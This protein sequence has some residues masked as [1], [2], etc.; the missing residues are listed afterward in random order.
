MAKKRRL[1]KRDRKIKAKMSI[2]AKWESFFED[3]EFT[4]E[5]YLSIE[6]IDPEHKG[7]LV[8]IGETLRYCLLDDKEDLEEYEVAILADEGVFIYSQPY[9]E[10]EVPF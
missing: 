9:S 10:S 2:K 3:E 1:S 6:S 4:N 5:L 8:S 7:V